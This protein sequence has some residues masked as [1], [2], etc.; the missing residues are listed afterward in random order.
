[1]L[2]DNEKITLKGDELMEKDKKYYPRPMPEE[3]CEY[4]R[5]P[6]PQMPEMPQMPQMPTGTMPEMYMNPM[7]MMLCNCIMNC[8]ENVLGIQMPGRCMPMPRMPE[9]EMPSRMMPPCQPMYPMCPYPMMPDMEDCM[10]DMEDLEGMEDMIPR[11]PMY[12][13][14]Y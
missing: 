3:E 14:R 9:R 4:P 12:P 8:I 7:A 5:M 13:E 1:M 2:I 10:D 11:C 6:Q